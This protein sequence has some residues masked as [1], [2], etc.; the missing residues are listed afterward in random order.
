MMHQKKGEDKQDR[1][2][3]GVGDV[4]GVGVARVVVST[5]E[6]REGCGIS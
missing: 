3:G 2:G 4:G 1:G 5:V 6:G